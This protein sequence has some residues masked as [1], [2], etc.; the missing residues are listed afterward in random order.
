MRINQWLVRMFEYVIQYRYIIALM[1]VV[2]T[3]P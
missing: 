3:L 1:S 2:G